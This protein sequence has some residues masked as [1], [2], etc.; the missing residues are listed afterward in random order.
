MSVTTTTTITTTFS[1]EILPWTLI[2]ITLYFTQFYFKYFNRSYPLPGPL[3]L[4]IVGNK[5]QYRGNPATWSKDLYSKYGDIC[6]LYMGSERQIWISR[7][8]LAA[9]IFSPLA[10]NNFLIR[11][12][13]N[14]G[15]DEIDMTTKGLTFNLN[16]NN[17]YFNRQFFN[18]AITSPKF[19]KQA[20]VWTQNVDVMVVNISEWIVRFI[21]EVVVMMTTN[22]RVHSMANYYHNKLATNKMPKQSDIVL[23]ESEELIKNIHSWLVGL[24]FFMDTSE[25]SRKF[26]PSAKQKAEELRAEI[27]KLNNT[28]LNYVEERRSEI[29]NTS[30]EELLTPDI[31]TMLLTVNTSR[32]ITSNIR[33]DQH[34]RPLTDDEIRGNLLEVIGAGIDTTAN[35]FAFIVY[36][37]AHYPEVKKQMLEELN[38]VFNGDPDRPITY[39]DINKLT[40]CDAIIKEV[41]RLMSIVPIIF[42]T[43]IQDDT[44][45]GKTIP[46]STQFMINTPMI[47]RHPLQWRDAEKFDPSR[48]LNKTTPKHSFLM[49]GNGLRMCPGK[50]LA[51]SQIKTLICL[52][53]MKYDVELEDMNAP[54]KFH[55]SIVKHCD[56]L[57]IRIKPRIFGKKN[58]DCWVPVR[59]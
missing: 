7:G 34:T 14:Q 56:D 5:L 52:L 10:S 13:P 42:R 58:N 17:W 30:P 48:F 23:Q 11:I 49:F 12:T 9:K 55:Y 29:D 25:F 43:S 37:V 16:V 27:D 20:I 54:L 53:Y 35:T 39:E 59:T 33:D 18:K 26:I 45:A 50:Q 19:I 44:I 28:F 40:Y 31:L 41:S 4:P 3:P 36:H 21:M 38:Q 51:M 6:E 57:K 46:A 22:K 1:S 24:Q 32:D 47:H 8:D 2:I 15:L